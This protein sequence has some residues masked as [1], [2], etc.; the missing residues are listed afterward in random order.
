MPT[1]L[2][3]LSFHIYHSYCM[4]IYSSHSDCH[5]AVCV[6]ACFL[7]FIFHLI[8]FCGPSSLSLHCRPTKMSI[9]PSPSYPLPPPFILAVVK[10]DYELQTVHHHNTVLTRRNGIK[11]QAIKVHVNLSFRSNQIQPWK[12][13]NDGTLCWL[14]FSV[15]LHWVIPFILLSQ[16]FY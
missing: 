5:Q 1:S 11:Q 16:S 4:Y 3:S 7:V 6:C 13:T 10:T 8:P 14:F 2:S 9:C 12:A 15:S